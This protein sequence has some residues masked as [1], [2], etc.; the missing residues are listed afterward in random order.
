MRAQG[1]VKH[2]IREAMRERGLVAEPFDAPALIDGHKTRV[3]SVKANILKIQAHD[4][5]S[6]LIQVMNGDPIPCHNIN[7]E[8]VVETEHWCAPLK[9]RISVAK[10]LSSKVM[11]TMHLI[12]AVD[13]EEAPVKSGFDA[14]VDAALKRARG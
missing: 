7:A 1:K 8:G 12:K 2:A 10:F 13:D 5:I 9:E 14:L 3:V 11:P 4:P 6:F